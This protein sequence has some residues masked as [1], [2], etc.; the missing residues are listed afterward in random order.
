M[1]KEINDIIKLSLIIRTAKIAVKTGTRFVYKPDISG[2]T[3]LTL[4]KNE[5]KKMERLLLLTKLTN[6]LKMV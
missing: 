1:N 3:I 5:L 2:P 6:L 4:I